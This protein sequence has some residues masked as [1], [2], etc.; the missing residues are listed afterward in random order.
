M[1][2]IEPPLLMLQVCGSNPISSQKIP[3]LY[4]KALD[5]PRGAGRTPVSLNYV[6]GAGCIRSSIRATLCKN[7]NSCIRNRCHLSRK[8][9]FT[10]NKIGQ[11]PRPVKGPS[12]LRVT[13][14]ALPSA[15]QKPR[16]RMS[17]TRILMNRLRLT[18]SAFTS[19]VSKFDRPSTTTQKATIQFYNEDFSTFPKKN[20]QALCIEIG[21][22]Y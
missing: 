6:K 21:E 19:T 7:V 8:Q 16:I 20:C 4:P 5:A 11:L 1:E 3:L 12:P 18:R 17:G 10:H 22:C 13:T 2:W 14:S 9:T 15:L